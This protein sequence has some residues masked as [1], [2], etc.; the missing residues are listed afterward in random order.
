MSGPHWTIRES[1][2]HVSHQKLLGKGGYGEVH[3][4]NLP[5]ALRMVLTV[6]DDRYQ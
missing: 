2:T 3:Q 1:E 5:W 4:V 6:E